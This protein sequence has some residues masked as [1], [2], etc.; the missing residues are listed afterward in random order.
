MARKRKNKEE[1][2]NHERWLITYADMITLL[3]VFFIVLYAMSE[4]EKEKFNA[5]IQS[6]R[7]AFSVQTVDK[8]IQIEPDEVIQEPPEYKIDIPEIPEKDE[9]EENQKE[10]DRLLVKLQ[11]YVQ[12]HNLSTEI[13]LVNLPRGVQITIKDSILFDE[14]SAKLIVE[15]NPVLKA[16]G[17]LLKTVPNEISIEGHTDNQPIV[18]ASQFESNWELSTARA[19][20]V[21][22]FLQKKAGINPAR[23]RV[24]GYGKYKPRATNQTPEGRAQ[25]RRVNIIVLR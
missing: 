4:I 14:G 1:Q 24:V 5:L 2:E 17:G 25:N 7:G 18:F 9:A 19:N 6:L 15:A 8:Q 13:D 20:S 10:L 16:V 11:K 23:L 12:E 22:E 3:M 21:R